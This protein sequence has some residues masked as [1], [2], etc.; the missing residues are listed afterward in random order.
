MK[1]LE[2]LIQAMNEANE[3]NKMLSDQFQVASTDS[4]IQFNG[5]LG[6]TGESKITLELSVSMPDIIKHYV[7]ENTFDQIS[8][9]QFKSASDKVQNALKEVAEEFENQLKTKM[10]SYGL[11][12]G[13]NNG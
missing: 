1:I 8:E 13:D 7:S 2:S 10:A 12:E 9:E 3:D 6:Y 5:K 11:Q 4:N